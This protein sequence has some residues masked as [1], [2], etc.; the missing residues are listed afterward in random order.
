M[1]FFSLNYSFFIYLLQGTRNND[2][3]WIKK[4]DREKWVY[5]VMRITLYVYIHVY[6]YCVYCNYPRENLGGVCYSASSA[7]I[8]E[9][10]TAYILRLV[11]ITTSN[12][13]LRI[14]NFRR[15]H[16]LTTSVVNLILIVSDKFPETSSVLT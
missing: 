16:F 13:A 5:H 12:P 9:G 11:N 15:V 2:L 7:V 14:N 8:S 6:T 1:Q 10:T 3:P 4:T